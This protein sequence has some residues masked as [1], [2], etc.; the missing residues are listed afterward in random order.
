MPGF[1]VKY[2]KKLVL[3]ACGVHSMPCPPP[4]CP[5]AAVCRHIRRKC[6]TAVVHCFGATEGDVARFMELA[7]SQAD[8]VP[9]RIVAASCACVHVIA[10]NLCAYAYSAAINYWVQWFIPALNKS[11]RSQIACA[12]AHPRDMT[13]AKIVEHKVYLRNRVCMV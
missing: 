3:F 2:P 11:A 6:P 9:R 5:G 13:V 1:V 10:C 4:P 8:V 12:F 7:V